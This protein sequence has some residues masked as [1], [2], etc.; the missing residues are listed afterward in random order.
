MDANEGDAIIEPVCKVLSDQNLYS[1]Q[2]ILLHF[3]IHY[4]KKISDSRKLYLL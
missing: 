4:E 1:L 3:C 2:E